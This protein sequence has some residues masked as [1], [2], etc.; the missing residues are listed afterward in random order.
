MKGRCERISRC[1][2]KRGVQV[3]SDALQIHLILD[4]IDTLEKAAKYCQL[5]LAIGKT[6]V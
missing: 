1:V 4:V 5:D 3:P 6:L 2:Y